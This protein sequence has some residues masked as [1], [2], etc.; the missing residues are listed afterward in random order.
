MIFSEM[1]LLYVLCAFPNVHQE[2]HG[3]TIFDK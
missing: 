3:V 2:L 1:K